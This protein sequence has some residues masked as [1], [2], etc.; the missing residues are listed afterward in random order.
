VLTDSRNPTPVPAAPGRDAG[1][2]RGRLGGWRSVDPLVAV[3]VVVSTAVYLLRGFD[4][5]IPRDSAFYI[6]A[7]QLV[8]EGVPPYV[9]LFNRVGP[10]AHLLPGVGVLGA[11]LVGG[12]DIVGVRVV[13]MLITVACVAGAYLLSRDLFR[14]RA[15]GLASAAAV[16]CFNT[17]NFYATSGPREKTF[18]A[19]CLIAVMWA[20]AHQRWA[21]AGVMIAVGTLTWQPMFFGA[22]AGA[23]LAALLGARGGRWRALLRITVGGAVPALVTV[24]A[25]A[26]IGHFRTFL[27]SFL[28]V[29]ARY[30][31][32]PDATWSRIWTTLEKGYLWSRWVL[33][34]GLAALLVG[35]V[36]MAWRHRRSWTPEAAAVVGAAVMLLVTAYWTMGSY[37]AWPDSMVF[38]PFA[39]LGIGIVAAL[40]A[41]HVPGKAA[42]AMVA[43]W[44][45]VATVMAASYSIDSHNDVLDEHRRVVDEMM[46]ILPPDAQLASVQ[47]PLP[48]VLTQQRNPSKYQIFGLGVRPYLNDVWPGGIRGYGRWL[49]DHEPAAIVVQ[50]GNIP[51]WLRAAMKDE[52]VWVGKRERIVWFVDR[53]LDDSV[54]GARDLFRQD[55]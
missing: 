47:A 44:S 50:E 28:L 3:V 43:A 24:L 17:F 2:T 49:V 31:T 19:L 6:Y 5:G 34:L 4:G 22:F 51:N 48:L 9:G 29:N 16:L 25:Y 46:D 14:S 53:D 54:R 1:S 20:V 38:V 7:G 12:D 32:Q 45:V 39:A 37:N 36:V 15:V 27:D 10:F 8:A 11:R 35:A 40:L 42:V 21:T 18:M 55:R 41:H 26:A 13:F 33:L 52:Y 23:V 30:T